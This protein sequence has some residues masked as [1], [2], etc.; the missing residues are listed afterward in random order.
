MWIVRLALRRPYTIGVGA[1]LIF[2]MGI[3]SLRSMLIDIFPIIDIPVVAV[4][5]TYDGLSAE[6]M[7]RRIVLVSERAISTTVNGVSRIE[8][9]SIPGIGMLRIYFQP[10]TEIGGAIAQMGAVCQTALR[11][12][13]PGLTPPNI[14]QY[15]AS[16]VP[17][18]QL[19]MRS[20]SMPEER[21]AD[22]ALNFIRSKLFTIP[23]LVATAPYGGKTRQVSVDVDPHLTAAKGLSINDVM[24]SVQLSNLILP[25]GTARIGDQEFNIL[26]NSS[27]DK[28]A[29]FEKIP[30]KVIGSAPITL[31]EVASVKDGFADQTN[32][33][34]VDGKRASYLNIL[35][36]SDSSTLFVVESLKEALHGIR[37]VAPKGL[38]I[39]LDFDQSKFVEDAIDG[40]LHE[41]LIS[42]IL[43]SIMVLFFLGSWRSVIVICTSIPLSILV[44][45]IGLKLTWV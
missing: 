21:I 4:I 17:V 13:P 41:A 42:S 14:I 33:V 35:K 10:G 12:M 45:V 11:V 44:G 2:I 34:R 32:V 25:A 18:A 8:S 29:D 6:D 1:A 31:G 37:D 20:D 26:L 15:N 7:E 16:N 5:W 27:P 43:V 28:I 40:V 23:G 3:L 36:K 39:A 30:L 9:D 24:N 38:N 22:Y 19:N